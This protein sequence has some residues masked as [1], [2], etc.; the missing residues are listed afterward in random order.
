MLA[1]RELETMVEMAGLTYRYP[2]GVVALDGVDLV[3]QRGELVILTG[4]SGA[5][6]TTLL[7]LLAGILRP[8]QGLVRVAGYDL[9]NLANPQLRAMRQRLGIVFQEFRLLQGHTAYENVAVSLRVLGVRGGELRKRSLEALAAV[10]L[11]GDAWRLASHLSWGQQQRVA[12]AR[13]VARRPEI[14]LA[15][16]PT[17]NLDWV[18]TQGIMELVREIHRQGATV[19][20]TTHDPTVIESAPAH[21]MTLQ[22]GKVGPYAR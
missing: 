19:V 4:A 16:E 15:D 18:T 10:G 5:G 1:H 12:L 2:D 22:A 6:K 13:A 21:L 14:L 20:M 7:R 8:S 17:G 9:G 3:V 11:A